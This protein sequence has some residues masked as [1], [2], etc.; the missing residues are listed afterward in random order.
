MFEQKRRGSESWGPV[1]GD[2][3]LD[4]YVKENVLVIAKLQFKA[5]SELH[6]GTTL[7]C[8]VKENPTDP[9]PVEFDPIVVFDTDHSTLNPSSRRYIDQTTVGPSNRV[10]PDQTTTDRTTTDQTT[11]DQTTTVGTK[12]DQIPTDRSTTDW[13]NVI[14]YIISGV[15]GCILIIIIAE[16]IMRRRNRPSGEGHVD[17]PTPQQQVDETTCEMLS[18]Y[19]ELDDGS[20]SDNLSNKYRVRNAET[21]LLHNIHKDFEARKDKTSYMDMEAGKNIDTTPYVDMEAGKD[22]DTTPYMDME[23]VKGTRL[24]KDVATTMDTESRDS[25]QDD[26]S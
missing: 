21:G 7:R 8:L 13:T 11:T 9:E 20:D 17:N 24:E 6:N 16:I 15:T 2:R 3:R 4:R 22:I 12:T 18:I 5:D 23:A 25:R 26:G 10:A 1:L 14:L 19:E